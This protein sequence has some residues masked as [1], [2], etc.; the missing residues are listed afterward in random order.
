MSSSVICR[1]VFAMRVLAYT[2][3]LLIGTATVSAQPTPTVSGLLVQPGTTCGFI[4][5]CTRVGEIGLHVAALAS[6]RTDRERSFVDS[7][8]QLRGAV[9]FLDLAEV[10]TQLAGHVGRDRAG[11]FFAISSPASVYARLRFLPLPFFRALAGSNTRLVFHAQHD[12]V[13]ASLGA[14]EAPGIARTTLLAIGGKSYGPIDLDGSIGFVLAP[15]AQNRPQ[16]AAFTLG[17]AGSYWFARPDANRPS[18]QLR[19]Q[20]EALYQFAQDARFSNQGTILAG[21]LGM[22][23]NGFGGSF[24]VGPEFIDSYVGVRILGGLQFSWGPHVRNPWAERKAAEPKETP[25]WIWSLLGAIDPILREDGCV[26]S[27]PTPQRPSYRMF[28]VGTPDPRDPQMIVLDRGL[29]LPVGTH[30]W[31]HGRVMRLNDGTKVADIPLASRFRSAVL[32]YVDTLLRHAPD[33]ALCEGKIDPIPRGLDDGWA[34][35]V[36]H[37]DMGGAAAVLGMQLYRQITC[38]PEAQSSAQILSLLGKVAGKGPLRAKPN[39]NDDR[40]AAPQGKLRGG[41]G[42]VAEHTQPPSRLPGQRRFSLRENEQRGGHVLEKHVGKTEEQLKQRLD[43]QPRLEAVSTFRDAPTAEKAISAALDKNR[44][45]IDEWLKAP[46]EPLELL[47]EGT[48]SLGITL[49]RGASSARF[50]SIARII[51]KPDTS[52]GFYV[53]TAYLK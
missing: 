21:L 39:L 9:T 32:D 16:Q 42:D 38:D 47:F 5:P 51:L 13:D 19:L 35:V 53:L 50:S 18:E 41:S 31:E 25:A 40:F 44:V 15:N 8:G 2:L 48:S 26:W 7:Q 37:D 17:F 34:S 29:R 6:V 33:P 24:A 11:G 12:F 3:S 30:L 49:E 28:C 43:D 52:G 46:K 22:T 20:L 14:H 4:A 23:R 27:D 10:G 36:A 1:A 45:A